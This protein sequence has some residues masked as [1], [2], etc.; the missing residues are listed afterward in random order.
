MVKETKED[1]PTKGPARQDNHRASAQLY[2]ALSGSHRLFVYAKHQ[3]LSSFL[4]S[5]PSW[6]LHIHN[7]KYTR[8]SSQRVTYLRRIKAGFT[9]FPRIMHQAHHHQMFSYFKFS[10]EDLK[11]VKVF[12]KDS[13][14]HCPFRQDS[15][16]VFH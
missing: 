11:T 8:F 13:L 4:N 12:G 2:V 7:F 15:L 6:S 16:K 9:F 5:D 1:K 3:S 14:F 10:L